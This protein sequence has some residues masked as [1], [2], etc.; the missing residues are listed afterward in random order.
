[1]GGVIQGIVPAEGDVRKWL[2]ETLRHTNHVMY[3]SEI[4]K[5]GQNDPELPHDVVGPYNKF[6][7]AV[8]CGCALGYSNLDHHDKVI[9]QMTKDSVHLHRNQY[10]HKMW[11]GP[12]EDATADDLRFGALDTICA[13]LENRPYYS[14]VDSF[15]ELD[16]NLNTII[17]GSTN[18]VLKLQ[19][20][21]SMISMMKQVERPAIKKIDRLEDFQN[22][23][24]S[25]G[26]YDQI[27]GRIEGTLMIL[28]EEKGYKL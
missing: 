7:W 18:K 8:I 21:S 26:M 5:V 9:F 1:M 17:E 15:D 14:H 2:L 19:W 23:G 6:E 10:H 22:V 11:D 12:D 27:A 20:L 28:R 4:L 13:L 3:Y 25:S 16:K 24:I